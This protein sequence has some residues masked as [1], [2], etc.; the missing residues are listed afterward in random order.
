VDPATEPPNPNGPALVIDGVRAE[1]L[2]K[3]WT[4]R[5]SAVSLDSVTVTGI[6]RG[7]TIRPD[8]SGDER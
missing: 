3:S 1:N 6:V 2:P 5:R 4:P 7:G 8:G